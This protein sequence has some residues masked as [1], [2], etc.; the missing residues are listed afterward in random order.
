MN[1]Q[2]S[3]LGL[4]AGRW[5]PAANRKLDKSLT[6][7]CS[8]IA[9]CS[10]LRRRTRRRSSSAPRM[11]LIPSSPLPE[12]LAWHRPRSARTRWASSSQ[13]HLG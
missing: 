11:S 12:M 7:S 8:Q 2:S 5:R 9:T 4:G 3:V 1:H 10:A 13:G 6:P